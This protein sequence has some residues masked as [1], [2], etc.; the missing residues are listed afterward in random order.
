M[1]TTASEPH[2]SC[3]IPLRWGDM[4]AFGH[5]NNTLY[6]RYCEEARFQWL[7]QRNITISPDNY[8]VVVTIACSFLRPVIYPETLRIDCFAAEPG[9]SSFMAYYKMYTSA[10]PNKPAAEAN[11]KIVWVDGQGKSRP[12]PDEVRGWF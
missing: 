4:D 10:E 7:S 8:P 9:R 6:L 2:F 11:S 1:D 12:L 3:E 5:V